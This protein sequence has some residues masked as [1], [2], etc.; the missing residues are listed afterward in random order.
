[1]HGMAHSFEAL[2]QEAA[3][4]GAMFDTGDEP[5]DGCGF[6]TGLLSLPRHFASELWMIL[7]PEGLLV[8]MI[9]RSLMCSRRSLEQMGTV[10]ALAYIASQA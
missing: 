10:C 4:A 8:A 1:M 9:P 2:K 5:T 7:V 3:R 6:P